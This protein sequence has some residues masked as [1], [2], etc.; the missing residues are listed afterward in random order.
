M[1]PPCSWQRA[2]FRVAH[3]IRRFVRPASWL[4]FHRGD[5]KI[6]CAIERRAGVH[7]RNPCC[8]RSVDISSVRDDS[9]VGFV[10]QESITRR[11]SRILP[12]LVCRGSGGRGQRERNLIGH[13][14]RVQF[15]RVDLPCQLNDP[16]ALSI[17][18]CRLKGGSEGC[19]RRGVERQRERRRRTIANVSAT[20]FCQR[21]DALWIEGHGA[22]DSRM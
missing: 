9:F 18:L 7:L 22:S 5:G 3:L 17:G 14:N 13:S 11:I 1:P 19:K 12:A 4:S 16:L 15:V 10:A 21:K 2:G 20:L 6:N 8:A